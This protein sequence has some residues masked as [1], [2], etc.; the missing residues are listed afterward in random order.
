MASDS[1]LINTPVGVT[2]LCRLVGWDKLNFECRLLHPL[3]SNRL[4]PHAMD[5]ASFSQSLQDQTGFNF[6]DSFF[7]ITG[8]G[9]YDSVITAIVNDA[10]AGGGKFYGQGGIA[11]FDGPVQ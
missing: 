11:T 2:G 4:Q 10:L 3:T 5:C 6:G 7:R 9:N 1:L 8:D